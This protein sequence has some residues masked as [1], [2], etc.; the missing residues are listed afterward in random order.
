MKT[1]KPG[2]CNLG[3]TVHGGFIW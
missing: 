1:I 2:D 3:P